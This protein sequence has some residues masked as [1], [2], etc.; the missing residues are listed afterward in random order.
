MSPCLDHQATPIAVPTYK[1]RHPE[2]HLRCRRPA[3]R[4]F[5]SH[6]MTA[7]TSR[8]LRQHSI[9][10]L[11]SPACLPDA[12]GNRQSRVDHH[13]ILLAHHVLFFSIE[14]F[15]VPDRSTLLGH[16]PFPSLALRFISVC[17][18][19]GQDL[20]LDFYSRHLQEPKLSYHQMTQNTID[21]FRRASG[22]PGIGPCFL[23]FLSAFFLAIP[24]SVFILRS[25]IRLFA[26]TA[27]GRGSE[28]ANQRTLCIQEWNGRKAAC[29]SDDI[30]VHGMVFKPGRDSSV[31]ICL[32]Y[33]VMAGALTYMT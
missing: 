26:S 19:G 33:S 14:R 4:R 28:Q 25:S 1:P 13:D 6:R 29:I 12:G 32:L 16:H 15:L 11:Q 30:R 18:Q 23:S 2:R 21:I 9:D 8:M 5:L 31:I 7:T 27:K 20:C 17:G 24:G 22:R 10:R 3:I